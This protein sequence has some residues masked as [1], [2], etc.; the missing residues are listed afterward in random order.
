MTSMRTTLNIEDDALQLVKKYA[1]ERSISLGQAVSDLVHRG[2]ES[3]PKFKTR[4]GW[5]IFNVPPGTPP[6]TNEMLEEWENADNEEE[7]RRAFSPR[8]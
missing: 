5:V 8:R 6:L 4:N 1:E 3:L 2:A 7:Y